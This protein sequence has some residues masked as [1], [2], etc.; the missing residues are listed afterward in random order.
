MDVAMTSSRWSRL[1]SGE[2]P[3]TPKATKVARRFRST[4]TTPIPQRVRPGSTP[5]TRSVT[6]EPSR[7]GPKDHV[8]VSASL[9]F[10]CGLHFVAEV[11][12]AVDVLDVV[13]LFQGVHQLHELL[14]GV[15]V[16]RHLHGRYKLGLVGVVLDA[17]F[18]KGIA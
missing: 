3:T 10:Q 11:G 18:L 14:G 9:G 7:P 12:V 16:Q 15:Q 13:E 2:V 5:N 4:S 8:W 17:G 1:S 6:V